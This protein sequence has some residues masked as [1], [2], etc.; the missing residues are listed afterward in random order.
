MTTRSRNHTDFANCRKS[1]LS[2]P[3][4]NSSDSKI[5]IRKVNA[6]RGRLEG[7]ELIC[8]TVQNTF[9]PASPFTD[10]HSRI[11]VNALRLPHFV[12]R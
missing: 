5:S 8:F 12:R 1:H 9:I 3:F 4:V 6:Q 10:M 7:G 2:S 11:R